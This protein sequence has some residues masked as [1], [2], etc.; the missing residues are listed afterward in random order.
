M[1][2][3]FNYITDTAVWGSI[4]LFLVIMLWTVCEKTINIWSLFWQIIFLI[5]SVICFGTIVLIYAIF[6]DT[7]N[8]ESKEDEFQE[9]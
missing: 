2:N 9:D 1:G 6:L 3:Q 8:T 7:L 4:L 5:G